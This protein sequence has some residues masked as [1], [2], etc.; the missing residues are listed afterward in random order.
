MGLLID[1]YNVLHVT[2]VLPESLAGLDAPGLADLVG[3]HAMAGVK[4]A[5]LVCDGS[6][7]PADDGFPRAHSPGV[8]IVYAGRHS[9]ADSLI[10]R[11]IEEDSA[12]RRLVVVSSDRRVQRA[13]RRRG[14]RVE[15]SEAFLRRIVARARKAAPGS[16]PGNPLRA[17]VPLDAYSTASWMRLFGFD[18][19]D[20]VASAGAARTLRHH[21]PAPERP[22]ANDGARSGDRQGAASPAR[23]PTPSPSATPT[24]GKAPRAKGS[25]P[26]L[27]EAL[28]AWEGRLNLEDLDM[29]KWIRGVAPLG[30]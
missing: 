10:E 6:G 24:P 13:A 2:G 3:A 14:A 4:T 19:H 11:L 15:E 16:A 18:A 28:R 1:T 25:D 27:A 12:P 9:D 8:S 23:P 29:H 7:G 5:L 26:V 20:L 21:E 22:A 17:Q 30:D